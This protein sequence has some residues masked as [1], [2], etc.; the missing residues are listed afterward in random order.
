MVPIDH[1]LC[2]AGLCVFMHTTV[3]RGGFE[4]QH[5]QPL[6][7]SPDASLITEQCTNILTSRVE[8]TRV[9]IIPSDGLWDELRWYKA[10]QKHRMLIDHLQATYTHITPTPLWIS[11]AIPLLFI[12]THTNPHRER[13]TPTQI[14]NNDV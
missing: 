11:S 5:L 12:N 10:M 9:N 6:P 2:Q 3:Q 13:D 8:S 4:N 7:R 1:V 14:H